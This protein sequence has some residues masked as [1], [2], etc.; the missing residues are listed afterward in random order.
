[1]GNAIAQSGTYLA[2]VSMEDSEP[3]YHQLIADSGCAEEG[4]SCLYNLTSHEIIE[5]Y[6]TTQSKINTMLTP[7][8]DDHWLRYHAL[9]MIN[10]NL[11]FK[12]TAN[13]MIGSVSDEYAKFMW[14]D[15]PKN[16]AE[17]DMEQ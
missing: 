9:D 15:T 7:T 5:A 11:H 1:M 10:A 2:A 3:V 16:L 17:D 4:A 8:I 6:A 13:V 14:N 12:P